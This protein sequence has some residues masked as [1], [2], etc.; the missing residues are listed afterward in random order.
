MSGELGVAHSG[1]QHWSLR[2][3]GP[4]QC[5]PRDGQEGAWPPLTPAVEPSPAACAWRA[6]GSGAEQWA[7]QRLPREGKRRRSAM[8]PRSGAAPVTRAR[9]GAQDDRRPGRPLW[10][11]ERRGSQTAAGGSMGGRRALPPTPGQ[12]SGW[13]PGFSSGEPPNRFCYPE[14]LVRLTPAR[15]PDASPSASV[16]PQTE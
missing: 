1:T 10:R 7:Q 12:F 4:G 2:R 3:V 11:K 9:T 15:T 16:L 13:H 8:S 6:G 5:R 14:A